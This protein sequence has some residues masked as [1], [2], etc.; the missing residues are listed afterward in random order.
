MCRVHCINCLFVLF[1]FLI[2]QLQSAVLN[3]SLYRKEKWL[4]IYVQCTGVML[5]CFCLLCSH[6]KATSVVSG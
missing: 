5:V 1:C 2:S 6:R 3:R 4:L